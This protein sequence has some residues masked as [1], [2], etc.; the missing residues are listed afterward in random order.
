MHLNKYERKILGRAASGNV[1]GEF[2]AISNLAA[3]GLLKITTMQD[4]PT[5][6]SSEMRNE[7]TEAGRK[8]IA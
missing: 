6:E 4:D 8:A 7:I 5:L 3:R 1:Y 2:E